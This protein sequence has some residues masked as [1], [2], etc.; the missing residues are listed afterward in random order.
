MKL[1]VATLLG[2]VVFMGQSRAQADTMNKKRKSLDLI[3]VDSSKHTKS[4]KKKAANK[5]IDTT[6]PPKSN[7]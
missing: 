3:N 4:W 7:R 5:A 6:N 1:F 2:L